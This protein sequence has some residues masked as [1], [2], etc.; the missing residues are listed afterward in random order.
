MYKQYW[1]SRL[2]L[3]LAVL[4]LCQISAFAADGNADPTFNPNGGDFTSIGGQSR[5]GIARLSSSIQYCTP[6][7]VGM[8]SWWSGDG[9]ALDARS[10]NNGTLQNG[11]TFS[12]GYVGQAFDL[13]GVDD[14]VSIPDSPSVRPANAMTAGRSEERRVGK[15]CAILC[16]S[17][18][19]PYH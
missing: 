13:D 5:N 15:E 19:S 12:T 17:R 14:Y 8:I 7:A 2:V 11:A 9:N 3:V 18:W 4:A 10:R 1:M 6:A 16:R